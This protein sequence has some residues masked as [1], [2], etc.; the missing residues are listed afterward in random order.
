[1]VVLSP[2]LFA[3]SVRLCLKVEIRDFLLYGIS[4]MGLLRIV[5]EHLPK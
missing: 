4:Y 5:R 3:R 1:M 2:L